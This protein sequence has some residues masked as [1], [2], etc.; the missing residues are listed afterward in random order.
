[1][2][3]IL[4]TYILTLSTTNTPTNIEHVSHNMH[5]YMCFNATSQGR[6]VLLTMMQSG[7]EPAWGQGGSSLP[8]PKNSIG[9][10]EEGGGGEKGKE[11]AESTETCAST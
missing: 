10:K 8:Y 3:N 4:H 6:G 9:S 5:I 11:E 7:A 2:C 1:M